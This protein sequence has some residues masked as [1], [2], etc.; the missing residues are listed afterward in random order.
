VVGFIWQ[1]TARNL[2]PYLTG[3]QNV[4][5]PMKLAGTGRRD[6]ARRAAELLEALGVAHC[7]GR[8]P[9]QHR[10]RARLADARHGPGRRAR[11]DRDDRAG[12]GRHRPGP[13]GQPGPA[14]R[15][16]TDRPARLRD[17]AADHGLLQTVVR[18]EGIT[19]LVATH[20]TALLDLADEVLTLQDGRIGA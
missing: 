11:G 12:A 15:R 2:L 7:A 17:R 19:A 16:R 5:M 8:I 1:Q 4:L 9:A 10:R 3:W 14:H 18:S 20:D 13:G 6:R